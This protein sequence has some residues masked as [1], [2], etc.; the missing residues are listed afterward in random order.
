MSFV[1]KN[2]VLESVLN[3][4]VI[5]IELGC[6]E[7]KRLSSSVGIDMLDYACV[8]IVGDAFDVLASLPDNSVK[9]VYSFHL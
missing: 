7:S 2:N 1:D 8:D 5:E 4:K 3:G 9:T 6:G